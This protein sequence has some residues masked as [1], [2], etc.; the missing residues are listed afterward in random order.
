MHATFLVAF[1]LLMPLLPVRTPPHAMFYNPPIAPRITEQRLPIL[2]IRRSAVRCCAA[3]RRTTCTSPLTRAA[4]PTSRRVPTVSTA[5]ARTIQRWTLRAAEIHAVWATYATRKFDNDA[6]ELLL[7]DRDALGD[8]LVGVKAAHS[9]HVIEE[10]CWDRFIVER[11]VG[12]GRA[13]VEVDALFI[14]GPMYCQS[15]EE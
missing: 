7:K 3:L 11:F 13:A 5:I 12:V 4:V 6:C 15:T 10:A 8:Y 9:F 1:S 2:P 14:F